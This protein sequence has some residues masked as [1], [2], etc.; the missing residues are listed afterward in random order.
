MQVQL[1]WTSKAGGRN[2]C[3]KCSFSSR[4]GKVTL[5]TKKPRWIQG[6]RTLN[7]RLENTPP[8][9]QERY[10]QTQHYWSSNST[11]SNDFLNLFFADFFF[12]PVGLAYTYCGNVS[13]EKQTA[14]L[15][16]TEHLTWERAAFLGRAYKYPLQTG[17]LE[18]PNVQGNW[19]VFLPQCSLAPKLVKCHHLIF[20]SNFY[21]SF[22][23]KKVLPPILLFLSQV[24]EPLLMLGLKRQLR[25]Q[26]ATWWRNKKGGFIPILYKYWH[27]KKRNSTNQDVAMRICIWGDTA[28]TVRRFWFYLFSLIP[29]IVYWM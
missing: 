23:K 24:L 27:L 3:E 1:L 16:D 11:F 6:W 21:I 8:H 15:W 5:G 17:K 9:K 13:T 22:F 25:V 19:G 4:K 2:S 10:F 28:T 20:P 12:S 18:A 7:T 26:Q 29:F 14:P